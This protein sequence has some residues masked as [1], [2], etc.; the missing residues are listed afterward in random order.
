MESA[1]SA[2]SRT[3][4]TNI[5]LPQTEG[6][7]SNLDS[8]LLYQQTQFS[9]FKSPELGGVPSHIVIAHSS[10]PRSVNHSVPSNNPMAS[11]FNLKSDANEYIESKYENEIQ[12]ICSDGP[13]VQVQQKKGFQW[14]DSERDLEWSLY[15]KE[16]TE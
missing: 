3:S 8:S 7:T 4:A 1:P 13:I 6:Y 11:P 14:T 15:Y 10:K 9:D 12:P 2:D 16:I 5:V